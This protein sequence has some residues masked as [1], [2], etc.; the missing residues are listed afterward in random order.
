MVFET[1]YG[2][3]GGGNFCQRTF[4]LSKIRFNSKS[5]HRRKQKRVWAWISLNKEASAPAQR[6]AI[7]LRK[8]EKN[9][10]AYLEDRFGMTSQQKG[11]GY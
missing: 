6:S 8:N 11:T 3:R 7:S 10:T 5:S 1:V 4:L 9:A 2:C